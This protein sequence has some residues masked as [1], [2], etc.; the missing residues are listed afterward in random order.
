LDDRVIVLFHGT[1]KINSVLDLLFKEEEKNRAFGWDQ[2]KKIS[3]LQEF[4]D[5]FSK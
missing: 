5:S 4:L 1:V 2:S 3:V